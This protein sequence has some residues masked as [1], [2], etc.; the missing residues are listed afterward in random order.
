M[1]SVVLFPAVMEREG[2]E[3]SERLEEQTR[4]AD[5]LRAQQDNEV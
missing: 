5:Y 1:V 4:E 2:R 3:L